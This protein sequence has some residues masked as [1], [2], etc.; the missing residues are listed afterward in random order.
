[1]LGI[2]QPQEVLPCQQSSGRHMKTA[3]RHLV[4][5]FHPAIARLSKQ[6]L[7]NFLCSFKTNRW[8]CDASDVTDGN[9]T[10][11]IV[12]IIGIFCRRPC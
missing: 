9:D 10:V 12:N 5:H 4:L 1:M 2:K 11:D 8:Q 3:Y 6:L 7:E